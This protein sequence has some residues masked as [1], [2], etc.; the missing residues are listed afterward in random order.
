MSNLEERVI[1]LENELNKLKQNI[2]DYN[3][4]PKCYKCNNILKICCEKCKNPCCDN[5]IR[6]KTITTNLTFREVKAS[7]CLCENCYF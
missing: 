1:E 2:I 7:Y 4:T 3:N 6:V 5:H